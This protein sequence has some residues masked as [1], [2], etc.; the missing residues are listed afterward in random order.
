MKN[1]FSYSLNEV[2]VGRAILCASLPAV[3]YAAIYFHEEI[4]QFSSTHYYI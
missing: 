1:D 2:A 4:R 3:C